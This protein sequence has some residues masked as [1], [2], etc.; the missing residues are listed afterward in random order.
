MSLRF[1]EITDKKEWG[2]FLFSQ[3]WVPFLQSWNSGEHYALSGSKVFRY[4]LLD[5]GEIKAVFLLV[6]ISAKRGDHFF[7]PYGP[8]ISDWNNK[9]YFKEIVNFIKEL[10]K[11]EK[12]NFVKISPYFEDKE[13][14]RKMFLDNGFLK[15]QIH[16]LSENSWL[17]NLKPTED[18][19]FASF[20]KTTRNLI[21][22]AQKEGVEIKKTTS[23]EAVDRFFNLY[24]ETG[25]RHKFVLY[26]KSFILNQVEAYKK[27]DQVLVFEAYYHGQVIS[28]AIVMFFGKEGAYHHGASTHK[29]SKVPSSYFLQWEA[30]K[31]AKKRG[32]DFYN[33]WGIYR[34]NNSNH[35]FKGITLFKTGFGG[36]SRE[37]LPCYDLP[38]NYKYWF[39]YFIEKYRKIKRGF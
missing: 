21:R 2:N 1:K 9:E 3:K 22:R 12:V 18:K 26:P 6:K 37:L 32:H 35:P 10:G 30:I 17:L 31:E 13:P 29:Y 8:I 24:K 14:T 34:G 23:P 11:K 36:F 5:D 38:I 4:G 27:D 7:C 39:N 20:R 28:S 25:S 16:I 33:F 19:I 15:A